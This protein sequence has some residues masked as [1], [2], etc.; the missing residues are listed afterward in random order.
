MAA[1]LFFLFWS[2]SPGSFGK[3]VSTL[4]PKNFLA[5]VFFSDS[6]TEEAL[7]A[8]YD[9]SK[10]GARPIRII[11]VPGHDNNSGGTEF[12]GV[13]EA[14]MNLE[15]AQ[16][17][18]AMFAD[19]KEF[20]IIL[21]R[22]KNGYNPAFSQFLVSQKDVISG[23]LNRKKSEMGQ[24]VDEG[25]ISSNLGGVYHNSVDSETATRL[26]GV[27]LWAN[28]SY[29][30]LVLS[31]HFNDYAGRPKSAPG[32]Y[33]G[34]AVY[35]PEGQYSN[36]KAS[37]AVA[38]KIF[39]HLNNYYARSNLPKEDRGIVSDQELIA[40]GAF[41]TLDPAGILIEYGYIYEPRFLDAKVRSLAIKDLAYQTYLGLNDFFKT[42]RFA[43]LPPSVLLVPELTSVESGTKWSPAVL[44]L[45]AALATKLFY[46]PAGKDKHD[47]PISGNFLSC[48]EK[49]LV[50][51]QLANGLKAEFGGIGPE[52]LRLLTSKGSI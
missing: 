43:S 49:A 6:I 48:T 27:N 13:R 40:V 28:Q 1:A 33:E 42:D 26:Y 32:E 41:N 31:I 16:D 35:V 19:D 52:T 24:L 22:D 23:F 7:F 9:K 46:P 12:K 8:R 10:A 47:C 39:N 20:E 2:L 36:S 25:L 38:Q 18:S 11:I 4:N 29:A 34:F 5:S 21:I 44:S 45:Q 15:L 30:D 17:L 50:A 51:F 14:D 37:Q 3:L